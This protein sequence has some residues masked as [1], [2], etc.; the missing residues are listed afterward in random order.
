M[1]SL[2]INCS[3]LNRFPGGLEGE[4]QAET[5]INQRARGTKGGYG[6]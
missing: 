1:N 3:F 4:I 6:V 2:N 5:V